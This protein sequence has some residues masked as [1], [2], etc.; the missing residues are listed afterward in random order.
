MA[1]LDW[2]IRANLKFRHLQLLVALDDLRNVGRVAAYLNVSQPAVS[3]TL[4]TLEEGLAVTLFERTARGMEPTEHGV[5]LIRHAR[6]ILGTLVS[7]RD[8]LLDISEGRITRVALGVLPAAAITLLPRVLVRLE[9]ESSQVTASVREGTMDAFLP[10][11]RAG[12][13]DLAVGVLPFRALGSEF[14]VEPLYDDPIV[15]VVRRGHP[16]SREPDPTWSM[17]AG[18]PMVLPPPNTIARRP[19]DDFLA[20]HRVPVSRRHVESVSTLTNVGV[21]QLSDSVGFLSQQLALHF[22]R[23]GALSVLPLPMPDVALRIG[24]I[25]IVDRRASPS[26]Q[27]LR[28]LFREVRDELV[29]ADVAAEPAVASD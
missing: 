24:L 11:L 18:F 15:V 29:G 28:R 4:A 27:L 25:S 21:L 17:V 6:E 8:E 2:Y 16:L 5:C 10:A 9:S 19:I 20:E 23:L 13:L 26:E 7:A 12:D 1:R 22:V 14:G 3:K